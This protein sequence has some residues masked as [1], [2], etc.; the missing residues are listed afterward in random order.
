MTHR[1]PLDVVDSGARSRLVDS[2]SGGSRL[3]HSQ[4]RPRRFLSRMAARPAV[5][6]LQAS[7]ANSHPVTLLPVPTGI[8]SSPE[9]APEAEEACSR[10][11]GPSLSTAQTEKLIQDVLARHTQSF[12]AAD[13]F[14][15]L[16]HALLLAREKREEVPCVGPGAEA[17]T[18]EDATDQELAADL[19]LLCPVFAMCQRYAEAAKP[20]AGTWA[21]VTKTSP[22][23]VE[24]TQYRAYSGAGCRCGCGSTPRTS[25]YLPGHDS[26]HL[27]VLLAAVRD[28]SLSTTSARG[29]LAHSERLQAK[30]LAYLG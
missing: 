21:G 26:R 22:G 1:D 12:A 6:P 7:P 10:P 4:S 27:S 29:E 25:V 14:D 9:T 11:A 15:D 17:W 2:A 19:C 23:H 5:A 3:S 24:R 18:S 16:S 13:A 20:Q 8:A 28:G 30:L